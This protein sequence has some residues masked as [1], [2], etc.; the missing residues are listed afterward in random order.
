VDTL[1]DLISHPDKRNKIGQ[2][3]RKT[4][5]NQFSL[6]VLGKKNRDLFIA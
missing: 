1:I 5:E 3:G 4:I 6:P 2:E